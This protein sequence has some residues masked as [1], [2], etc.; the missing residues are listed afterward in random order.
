MITK[1]KE[2][3]DREDRV[4][5]TARRVGGVASKT[6]SAGGSGI[7]RVR[8][9]Y[10]AVV[11]AFMAVTTG[12]AALAAGMIGRNLP[13]LAGAGCFSLL[14]GW[15]AL[16]NARIAFGRTSSMD[17]DSDHRLYTAS[18]GNAQAAPAATARLAGAPQTGTPAG[19]STIWYDRNSLI[20]AAAK[21]LPVCALLAWALMR[22][23]RANPLVGLIILAVLGF[24]LWRIATL[25][26]RATDKD[27]T[28]IAWDN[29]QICVR[30][31]TSSRQVPWPSVES[32]KAT[33]RV[34]RLWGVIPVARSHELV[35]Q[36]RHNG[37]RRR[38]TVHATTLTIR[39]AE[40][41]DQLRRVVLQHARVADRIEGAGG[42]FQFDKGMRAAPP[43][44]ST[45]QPALDRITQPPPRT[46]EPETHDRA[47][48]APPAFGR[49]VT[50]SPILD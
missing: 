14:L 39:P 5:E 17:S 8:A 18:P 47:T 4:V 30:T 33:R 9:A 48:R 36:L 32:V 38:M 50:S 6:L 46:Q 40:A 44:L 24:A 12:W 28:A 16:R 15:L 20:I 25:L 41:E 37:A 11:C 35:F 3:W 29:Q 13:M 23:P 43:H 19:G 7:V 42:Q 45:G 2:A 34:R 31:L 22:G 10:V 26:L 49:K 1:P 21:L 27:L